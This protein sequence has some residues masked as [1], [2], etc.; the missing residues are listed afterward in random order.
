MATITKAGALF[1][2]ELVSE[3]FA[4]VSGHSSLAKLSGQMPLRFAGNDIFVFSM[5]GEASIV[6]EGANK[7][8]GNANF[9]TVSIKPIKFVY[10]HRV[11]D[12]FVYMAEEQQIE[13]IK[14]F[15]E[16]FS[17]K[18]ARALDISAIHNVNPHDASTS[19]VIGGNSFKSAVTNIVE[20]DGTKADDG[21]DK[22]INMV[23]SITG[24]AMS[25]EFS[26]AMGAI[27]TADGISIYPD[28]RFGGSPETLGGIPI[29]INNTISFKN[30]D[31]HAVVGDFQNAFR[32]GYATE[33]PVKI[34]DSG[35]PDGLGDLNRT[36]QVCLRAEAYI[37]WGILDPS[38]FALLKYK[39]K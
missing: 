16:G 10:Q 36:N 28:F 18:I 14:A 39:A 13:Y 5:D 21:L 26:N 38:A 20:Y 9:T 1:P 11:T 33:I 12:E 2:S 19:T 29:D 30:S 7:P 24:I 4:N 15:T 17:K 31:I 35:D 25:P 8:S 23:D 32:W 3:V 37:G 22:A 6:G 34:I 27:K